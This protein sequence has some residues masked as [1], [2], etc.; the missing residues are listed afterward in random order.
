MD[1][2]YPVEERDHLESFDDLA[3]GLAVFEDIR[4]SL[5][6]IFFIFRSDVFKICGPT[7]MARGSP[8][9]KDY[10]STPQDLP[11]KKWGTNEERGVYPLRV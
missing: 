7:G 8:K 2:V 3:K 4:E 9:K 5:T 6:V 1:T 11:D 10:L